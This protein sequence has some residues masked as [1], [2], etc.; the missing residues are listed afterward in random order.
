M[1]A[2]VLGG[3]RKHGREALGQWLF[4]KSAGKSSGVLTWG[5]RCSVCQLKGNPPYNPG[6]HVFSQGQESLQIL[7]VAY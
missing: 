5:G 1:C 2:C 7:F 4:K 3:C 6:V